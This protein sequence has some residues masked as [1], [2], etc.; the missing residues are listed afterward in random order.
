[1]TGSGERGSAGWI[2]LTALS[3]MLLTAV[4]LRVLTGDAV[5][6]RAENGDRIGLVELGGGT[7]LRR[8]V[9]MPPEILVSECKDPIP[10][11]FAEP[12]PH[13]RDRA[14]I[15]PRDANDRVFYVYRGWVIGGHFAPTALSVLDVAW[16]TFDVMSLKGSAEPVA[17]AVRFTIPARCNA[18]PE[19]VLAELRRLAQSPT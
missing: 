15:A 3:L 19:D 6:S 13:G 5:R 14:L 8:S 12:L 10:V 17:L 16:R 7:I 1:M 9:S 2:A 4:A 11:E 18:W